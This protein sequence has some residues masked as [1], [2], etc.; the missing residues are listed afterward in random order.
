LKVVT[1]K[2]FYLT[3]PRSKKKKLNKS[4]PCDPTAVAELLAQ[5]SKHDVCL[6]RG[7]VIINLE[8][9]A[10]FRQVISAHR[11]EY[12]SSNSG[13]LKRAVAAKV[14]EMIE[15]LDPPGRF[16]EILPDATLKTVSFERALGKTMQGLREKRGTAALP[17]P[18]N[19]QED[20]SSAPLPPVVERSAKNAPVTKTLPAKRKLPPKKR[21]KKVPTEARS[22]PAILPPDETTHSTQLEPVDGS[23]IPA[24]QRDD[25][26]KTTDDQAENLDDQ[27]CMIDKTARAV[28][29]GGR[30]QQLVESALAVADENPLTTLDDKF[31]LV[32]PALTVF[33]SGMYSSNNLDNVGN[34]NEHGP[35]Y[36]PFRGHPSKQTVIQKMAGQ[37][38]RLHSMTVDMGGDM[39]LVDLGADPLLHHPTTAV[40][41]V[42]GP[43]LQNEK[44]HFY[45]IRQPAAVKLGMD[46]LV[47]PFVQ[48]PFLQT[49]N[50]LFLDDDDFNRCCYS[51]VRQNLD[52][53]RAPVFPPQLSGS[54]DSPY[55]FSIGATPSAF[56]PISKQTNWRAALLSP[57]T[58]MDV[59]E[60]P[61]LDR[62]K[63][64]LFLEEQH[65]DG[66][67]SDNGV[68]IDMSIFHDTSS[69]NS[70]DGI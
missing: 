70:F 29:Q 51:S 64:S 17:P 19:Q 53:E 45:A 18:S 66:Q 55:H 21:I 6:G 28:A 54:H 13:V 5:L 38:S 46:T 23:G 63:H 34:S 67:D 33:V 48:P 40:S 11:S 62:A 30:L 26:N 35:Y 44:T 25:G 9:N 22:C 3:M 60:P 14:V 32:P 59:V 8:G 16:Y 20:N 50:S 52:A 27:T 36:S 68:S 61:E 57:D 56:A 41:G 12:T 24:K 65:D 58:V 49:N 39:D 2:N 47:L 42:V 7:T 10:Y 4:P 43:L 1:H 15:S 69:R 37:E 31:S